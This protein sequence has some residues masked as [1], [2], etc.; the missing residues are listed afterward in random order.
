ML[1]LL[2]TFYSMIFPPLCV[3]CEKKIENEDVVLCASCIKNIMLHSSL[4][5]PF[6][7]A[8]V[9]PGEKICHTNAGYMLAAATSYE[10][11]MVRDLIHSLKYNET[12]ESAVLIAHIMFEY[13]KRVLPLS[14]LDFS[15]YIAIP[16]PLYKRKERTRGYNQSLLIAQELRKIFEAHGMVFPKICDDGIIRNTHT[17]SQTECRN[18]KERKK[19]IS[20][21][22]SIS[23]EKFIEKKNIMLI[24]DVH[25]TGAT[26][27]EA[28]RV[29]K[30]HGA[31]RI[32]ALVCAK[33]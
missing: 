19:N 23:H 29:L 20:G 10:Q 17:L 33:T 3:S 24:D 11:K 1:G 18:I 5:C 28:V 25:T 30:Q 22:F 4:F 15:D 12:K 16:I 8:R 2:K 26:I 21:C 6:C 27:S 13:L 7:G 32:L 9:P 31:K 14:S